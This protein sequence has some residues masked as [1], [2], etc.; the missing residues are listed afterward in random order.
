MVLKIIERMDQFEAA[1]GNCP[2]KIRNQPVHPDH[3]RIADIVGTSYFNLS[4]EIL[5]AAPDNNPAGQNLAR[6]VNSDLCPLARGSGHAKYLR[7]KRPNFIVRGRV[8]DRNQG[9]NA[10]RV[11]YPEVSR[12]RSA[13]IDDSGF[14]NNACL[15]FG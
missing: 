8:R 15:S 14:Q 9:R 12:I 10:V 2:P 1:Q 11:Y 7:R 3:V 13:F 6:L 4:D 5:R